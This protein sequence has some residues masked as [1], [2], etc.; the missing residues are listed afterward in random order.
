MASNCSNTPAQ[1]AAEVDAVCALSEFRQARPSAPVT[2]LH[3][4]M[5][6][7]PCSSATCRRPSSPY[8]RRSRSNS[9][10][11]RGA[12]TFCRQHR[13]GHPHGD[14]PGDTLLAARKLAEFPGG[15]YAAPHYLA[16]HGEPQ[17]PDDLMRHQPWPFAAATK[18][19]SGNFTV[20]NCPPPSSTVRRTTRPPA[21]QLARTPDPSGP[22]RCRH[23]RRPRLLR[24]TL[25]PSG[26]T[27]PHPAHLVTPQPHRLGRL[28]RP[29]SDARQNPGLH[30]HATNGTGGTG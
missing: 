18:Q 23:H 17:H 27:T 6:S 15:L 4:L 28:P 22:R 1:V 14:L 21:G 20:R 26:R 7:P 11:P 3:A 5:I 10:C 9:T 19:T 16:E 24:P 29:P 8:I 25:G 13:P 30:R 2:G 12:F